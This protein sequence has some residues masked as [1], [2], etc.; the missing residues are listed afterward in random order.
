MIP[1]T[2]NQMKATAFKLSKIS[3][4]KQ[5]LLLEAFSHELGFNGYDIFQA[6]YKTKIFECNPG[7]MV[8]VINN[9]LQKYDLPLN[10]SIQIFFEIFKEL[11]EFKN[12]FNNFTQVSFLPT[13]LTSLQ[14][15]NLSPKT[16]DSLLQ[17]CSP[18][19]IAFKNSTE[20]HSQ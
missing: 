6:K 13:S 4:Q 16:V 1:I 10:K 17:N 3:S 19:K 11:K 14:E 12:L 15:M 9:L 7:D 2:V 18:Q 5:S 20:E 8:K